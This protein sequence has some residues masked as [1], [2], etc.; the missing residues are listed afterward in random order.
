M[1]AWRYSFPGSCWFPSPYAAIGGTSTGCSTPG[2]ALPWSV[3]IKIIIIIFHLLWR[4]CAL[5]DLWFGLFHSAS[6]PVSLLLVSHF[7]DIEVFG[8]CSDCEAHCPYHFQ[9]WCLEWRWGWE[10]TSSHSVLATPHWSSWT[11]ALALTGCFSGATCWGWALFATWRSSSRNHS[12]V[13]LGLVRKP[14]HEI[15]IVLHVTIA[16]CYYAVTSTCYYAVI[17]NCYVLCC[18]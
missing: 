7:A 8:K 5:F 2:L 9:S 15:G 12:R 6:I 16:T 1:G 11:I 13:S 14:V 10:V 18:Y 17:S 4:D 3:R